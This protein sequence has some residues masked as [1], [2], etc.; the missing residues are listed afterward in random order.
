M[1]TRPLWRTAM[2]AL[3]FFGVLVLVLLALQK[4]GALDIQQG[5]VTVIDGDSLREGTTEIRLYGIDAP[6]YQQTCL[7]QFRKSYACGKRAAQE[8]R[9]LVAQGDVKCRSLDVDRYGR[10]VSTCKVGGTDIAQAMVERGWAV[11][12][13]QFGTEYVAAENQAHKTKRGLWGGDFEQPSQY[14]KRM[15]NVQSNVAGAENVEPD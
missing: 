6:E 15:K 10:A 4:F 7:D 3:V 9:E 5:T 8:L 12:F 13:T 11:A 1:R 2:D 14:R